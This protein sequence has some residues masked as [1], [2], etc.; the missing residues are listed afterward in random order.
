[1]FKR[2]MTK[3][4]NTEITERFLKELINNISKG[5]L[6]NH[7]NKTERFRHTKKQSKY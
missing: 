6:K 3:N 2:K 5:L 1:M 4:C 7:S